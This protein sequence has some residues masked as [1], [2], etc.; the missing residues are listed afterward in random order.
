LTDASGG[1]ITSFTYDDQA[2]WPLTPDGDGPSLVINDE[3]A[4]LDPNIGTNWRAS[5]ASGGSPGS[6]EPAGSTFDDWMTANGFADPNAEYAD[7]GLSNLLAYALGRDLAFDVEPYTG[8][9]GGFAT[10]SHRKRIGDASV[11]YS[12][13]SSTD[14]ATWSP[15]GDLVP[16]GAPTSNGDGTETV[17]LRSTLPTSGRVDTF[18][19]LRVTSP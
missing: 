15:A 13:E 4:D 6:A 14:L 5:A 19:R 12:V 3:N 17:T 16:D 9:S 7:S 10:F 18:Y 8:D 1:L 11:T 2:P